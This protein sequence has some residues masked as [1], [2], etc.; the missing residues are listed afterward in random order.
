[1]VKRA[2][3][4]ITEIKEE[5]NETLSKHKKKYIQIIPEDNSLHYLKE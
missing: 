4:T 2:K 3:L 5:V 1:L